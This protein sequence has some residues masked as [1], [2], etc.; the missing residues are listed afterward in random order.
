MSDWDVI[1]PISPISTANQ[2]EE[3]L[4]FGY[5]EEEF[6]EEEEDFFDDEDF[7]N[8]TV[9]QPINESYDTESIKKQR[10][11]MVTRNKRSDRVGYKHRYGAGI[12]KPQFVKG[13]DISDGMKLYDE[14]YHSYNDKMQQ[15]ML[16]NIDDLAPG[17][18]RRVKD[19]IGGAGSKVIRITKVKKGTLKKG[20]EITKDDIISERIDKDVH[21]YYDHISHELLV[22]GFFVEAKYIQFKEKALAERAAYGIGKSTEM[23]SLYC[24]WCFY[25]REHFDED[26]YNEFL[27]CAREDLAGKS[28]YGIECFFRFASYGLE[29]FWNINVFHDFE[30]EALASYKKGDYYGMEKLKAFLVNQKYDFKIPVR[31]D[32]QAILDKYPTPK[33]FR[34]V[35]KQHVAN[36]QRKNA[37]SNKVKAAINANPKATFQLQSKPQPQPKPQG[38]KAPNN[39][40]G[41]NASSRRTG[42]WTFGKPQP[43]SVPIDSPMR[44]NWS[45]NK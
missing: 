28:H 13:Y 7:T 34:E 2:E 18:N 36:S 22:D 9:S 42:G 41:G 37:A 6:Y 25:L 38:K 11:S 10:P 15:L 27:T 44:R 32:I 4:N 1:S 35:K 21:H 26:M 30:N 24:F 8:Y 19:H 33:S 17:I 12:R 39:Q 14:G 45:S 5:E 23:N 29:T 16:S 43:A 31:E 3:E 20:N 40:R